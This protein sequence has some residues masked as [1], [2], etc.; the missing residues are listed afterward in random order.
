MTSSLKRGGC[1]DVDFSEVSSWVKFGG[2]GG[3][4][5]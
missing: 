3:V 2:L 4:V 1:L 5:V